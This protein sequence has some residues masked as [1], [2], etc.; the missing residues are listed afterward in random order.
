MQL[1]P[2]C[3]PSC[4]PGNQLTIGV[5]IDLDDT[6]TPAEWLILRVLEKLFFQD[7][8]EF[9]TDGAWQ[10][11]LDSPCLHL[12]EVTA[13]SDGRIVCLC[14]QQNN[15]QSNLGNDVGSSD[16]RNP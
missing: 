12:E 8:L 14:H 1:T 6:L 2:S 13:E 10:H 7:D 16:R 11:H 3:L 9:R 4:L 5:I 15:D